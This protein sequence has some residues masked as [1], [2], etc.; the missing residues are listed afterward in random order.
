MTR[1][2]SRSIGDPIARWQKDPLIGEAGRNER[3]SESNSCPD[4]GLGKNGR[5]VPREVPKDHPTD[6]DAPSFL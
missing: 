4:D 1:S 3:V 6:V 2:E 5:G